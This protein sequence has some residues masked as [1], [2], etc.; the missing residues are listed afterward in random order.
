M[1]L[2][3]KLRKAR[4]YVRERRDPDSYFQYKRKREH[5]REDAEQ[6]RERESDDAE[7][8]RGEADRG[9]EYEKRYTADRKSDIAEK[10]TERGEETEPDP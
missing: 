10:G 2:W 7:E 6:A 1:G 9:R 8:A 4:N 5:D 3:D